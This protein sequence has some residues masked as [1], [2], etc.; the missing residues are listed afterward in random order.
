MNT[1]LRG[2]GESQQQETTHASQF[3]LDKGMS[4]TLAKKVRVIF[5]KLAAKLKRTKT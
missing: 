5:G 3:L 2:D 4:P 1:I